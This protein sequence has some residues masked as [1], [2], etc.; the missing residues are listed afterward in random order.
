MNILTIPGGITFPGNKEFNGND[1]D[2]FN[3][4][5]IF[6]PRAYADDDDDDDE[7]KQTPAN[8]DRSMAFFN[9]KIIEA[10]MTDAGRALIRS[11]TSVHNIKVTDFDVYAAVPAYD[12]WM[13]LHYDKMNARVR[14]KHHVLKYLKKRAAERSKELLELDAD[15]IA[16]LAQMESRRVVGC[17]VNVSAL[18]KSP[19][20]PFDM[21]QIIYSEPNGCYVSNRR[22]NSAS[23]LCIRP[24][25]PM[26]SMPED[27]LRYTRMKSTSNVPKSDEEKSRKRPMP[28]KNGIEE[29]ITKDTGIGLF[30]CTNKPKDQT[31]LVYPSGAFV[32][33]GAQ[34]SFTALYGMMLLIWMLACEGMHIDHM[35]QFS[36]QNIVTTFRFPHRIDLKALKEAMRDELEFLNKRFPAAIFHPDAK[37]IERAEKRALELKQ[38]HY[39]IVTDKSWMDADEKQVDDLLMLSTSCHETTELKKRYEDQILG[40]IE[41]PEDDLPEF[42]DKKKEKYLAV[43]IHSTGAIVITGVDDPYVE[44][45]FYEIIYEILSRFV[46]KSN[47]KAD[48]RKRQ[49]LARQRRKDKANATCNQLIAFDTGAENSNRSIIAV[50]RNDARALIVHEREKRKAAANRVARVAT[51]V[52]EL[53]NVLQSAST[54]S[55]AARRRQVAVAANEDHE[56]MPILLSGTS[57]NNPLS[58]STIASYL[59]HSKS[60]QNADD[61]STA[62]IS[63]GKS[64]AL[65]SGGNEVQSIESIIDSLAMGDD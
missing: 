40:K 18:G 25:T 3:E 9:N 33:T 29:E 57:S 16:E 60:T 10:S 11:K 36:P 59:R 64:N 14:A 27:L 50:E 23:R 1:P 30:A 37:H 21:N 62:L 24:P 22:R 5:A 15:V 63:V 34:D 43:I 20:G 44:L 12:G 52:A 61:T 39:D 46:A 58:T 8:K 7:L 56:R 35:A 26:I 19:T 38:L 13:S 28:S 45:A 17:T 41:R 48:Q 6:A 55:N 32:L 42:E 47:A 65:T 31:F 53:Q 51:D 49:R 2:R 4:D 54:S